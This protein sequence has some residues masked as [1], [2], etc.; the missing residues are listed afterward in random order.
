MQ[1]SIVQGPPFDHVWLQ[2]RVQVVLQGYQSFTQASGLLQL[3]EPRDAFL[4]SL[5]TYTLAGS[6]LASLEPSSGPL[7][8]RPGK[9]KHN[10][11]SSHRNRPALPSD[12]KLHQ[13]SG[14]GSRMVHACTVSTCAAV[15]NL[16]AGL[17]PGCC[18]SQPCAA[19]GLH[20]HEALSLL[21]AHVCW[22]ATRMCSGR[23]R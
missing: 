23:R 22:Q 5:C 15:I 2:A 19:G 7:S 21:R 1:D 17:A 9:G 20:L 13:D 10:I 8:P 11:T 18:F 14:S 3:H 4:A 16:I 6:E 12:G